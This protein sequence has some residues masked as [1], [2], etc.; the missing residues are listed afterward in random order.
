MLRSCRVPRRPPSVRSLLPQN[1]SVRTQSAVR[2]LSKSYNP[3]RRGQLAQAQVCVFPLRP[4]KTGSC[5]VSCRSARTFSW[6]SLPRPRSRCTGK[7]SRKNAGLQ[8]LGN[9][10]GL[11]CVHRA[12][13]SGVPRIAR[14]LSHMPPPALFSHVSHTRRAA[15]PSSHV[16]ITPPHSPKVCPHLLLLRS[17][18]NRLACLSALLCVPKQRRPSTS[19]FVKTRRASSCLVFGCVSYFLPA[20][21]RIRS[22][23]IFPSP[24]HNPS[25]PFPLRRRLPCPTC[26]C[27]FAFIPATCANRVRVPTIA[28][29]HLTA[30]C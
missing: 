2:C 24:S 16:A 14:L 30:V 28:A 22:S 15:F 25:F 10:C 17:A 5:L 6:R 19:S 20:L 12:K 3:V 11:S 27:R 21:S 18:V 7:H 26:L 4:L 23:H 13:P 9:S 1:R 29:P 8:L